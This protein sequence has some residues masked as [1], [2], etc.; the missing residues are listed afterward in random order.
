M[1]KINTGASDKTNDDLGQKLTPMMSNLTITTNPVV[2]CGVQRKA[3]IGD[4]ET[5]DAYC[6]VAL[7]LGE[8]SLVDQDALGEAIKEAAAYGFH[9]TSS[10]TLDRYKIIKES[11]RRS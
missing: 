10:E 4:F 11:L 3:N 6:A 9:V 5:I 2:I 1:A 8:V 7:P